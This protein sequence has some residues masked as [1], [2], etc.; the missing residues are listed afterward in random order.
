MH[1]PRTTIWNMHELTPIKHRI[2][3]H[4]LEH[5]LPAVLSQHE[6]IRLFDCFAG[7]GE[8]TGG[9]MGS[10]L[11][12]IDVLYQCIPDAEQRKKVELIFI[13]NHKRRYYHLFNMIKRYERN[14]PE[15]TRLCPC[16]VYSTFIR[17]MKARLDIMERHQEATYQTFAFIDPFGFKDIP[18]S[19]T[20]RMTRVMNCDIF[21]T[22]M[23]EELNR[24]LS[25][26]DKALQRHFTE[27]FG[28]EQWRDI[29]LDGNREQQICHLYRSQLQTL[30]NIQYVTMFRLQNQ[31]NA[32]DYF[33]VFGTNRREN[34]EMMKD[35]FWE[36]DPIGGWTYSAYHQAKNI[37]NLRLFEPEPD[38]TLLIKQLQGQFSGRTISIA[39]L[40]EYIMAETS[41]RTTGDKEHVLADLERFSRITVIS[42][43]TLRRPGE[44]TGA[45]LVCF[46]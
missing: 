5:W 20:A 40:D 32:T 25:K 9:E 8:Y 4:Y 42:S 11:I 29:D 31:K 17:N 24:F 16:I 19:I 23:Y 26:P 35:A 41:F 38:Y 18:M 1:A 46:Q 45:D 22:L 3:R 10:P 44:Y 21:I 39:E 34:L 7:P 14:E 37:Y 12:A 28:T 2:L 33:L 30:G 36:I 13:D 43:N 27:L 6:C 15:I